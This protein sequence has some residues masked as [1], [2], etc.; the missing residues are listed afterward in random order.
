MKRNPNGTV[1]HLVGHLTFLITR[2]I[3][4]LLESESA[5]E[6]F[7]DLTLVHVDVDCK[8]VLFHFCDCSIVLWSI[9]N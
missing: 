9:V 1:Y 2:P 4:I 5:V 3:L 7:I 8:F 6:E